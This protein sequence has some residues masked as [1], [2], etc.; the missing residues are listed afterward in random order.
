M[1]QAVSRRPVTVEVRVRSQASPCRICGGQS[2]TG[3]SFSSSIL[4]FCPVI[5]Y[6]QFSTLI[7][8]YML[9]LPEGQTDEFCKPFKKQCSFRNRRE[10]GRNCLHFFIS[11]A[12]FH[13]WE[14]LNTCSFTVQYSFMLY[15]LYSKSTLYV[16]HSS[17]KVS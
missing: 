10:F 6:H 3:T 15:R 11:K 4:G 16:V 14:R 12:S 9:L 17:S 5:S 2:G 8:S 1:V 7:F 13:L